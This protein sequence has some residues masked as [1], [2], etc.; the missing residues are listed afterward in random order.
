[1]RWRS[2]RSIRVACTLALLAVRF[3]DRRPAIRGRRSFAI[4]RRCFRGGADALMIVVVLP[5]HLRTL[6][7]VSGDVKLEIDGEVT[8]R[9]ILDHSRLVI[10]CYAEPFAIMSRENDVLCEVLCLCEDVTHDSPDAHYPTQS[11][12]AR[13]RFTLSAP[14]PEVEVN[15]NKQHEYDSTPPRLQSAAE[16]LYRAF[17]IQC[18]VQMAST[19]WVHGP[20]SSSRGESRRH[21]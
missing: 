6:A 21:L 9:S 18:D 4:F 7:G 3:M 13:S 10:R 15:D 11:H 20:G 16:R 12:Q 8:R 19:K 1:M 2:T 17:L 5:A 14:S